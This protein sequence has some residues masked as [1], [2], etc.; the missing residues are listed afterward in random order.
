LLARL[1]R[2]TPDYRC[3]LRADGKFI[4]IRPVD[5]GAEVMLSQ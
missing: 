4:I 5:E 3:L 1:A 2:P